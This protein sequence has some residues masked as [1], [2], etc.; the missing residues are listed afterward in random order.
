MATK[1]TNAIKRQSGAAL[2][3]FAFV[4]VPLLLLTLGTLLYG[5]VFVTQQA[6]TFAA[7]SGADAMVQV[8]PRAYS[9]AGQ[10]ANLAGYCAAGESLAQGRVTDLLP[11]V[12]LFTPTV[13][14]APVVTGPGGCEV[15][16]TADFPIDI[17]LLPLPDTITGVGFV[18]VS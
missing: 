5:L 13:A 4:L 11:Q 18:P 16:V 9:Q 14:V 1:S 17:P 7:Q 8:D 12:A 15:T 10:V 6:M 2:I 3:E